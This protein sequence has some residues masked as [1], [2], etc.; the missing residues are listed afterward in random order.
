MPGAVCGRGFEE[1]GLT[2]N[3][4][5]SDPSSALMECIRQCPAVCLSWYSSSEVGAT[6]G[7]SHPVELALA[8]SMS[9]RPP[10][11]LPLRVRFWL[12]T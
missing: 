3:V 6:C 2:F 4:T 11:S 12:L 10:L 1:A 9:V 8:K 5:T 7:H